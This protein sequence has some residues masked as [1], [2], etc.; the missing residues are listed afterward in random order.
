PPTVYVRGEI[1]RRESVV[2]IVGSRA[3]TPYGTRVAGDLARDLS[4]LGFAIVSGLAR[5]I[6]AAAHRGALEANGRTVAVL[7]GGLDHVTPRHHVQLAE[8]IAS[9]GGLISEWSAG[10]PAQPGM[11][12]RRNRLI[13]ALAAAV[14]VVEAGEQSGAL[15]TAAAARRLERPLFAVPGD[16]DRPQSRGCLMLLRGVAQH[17]L[18]LAFPE[19]TAADR[20][21][22]LREHY[23]ELGRVC[24]EYA[25]LGEL[26]RSPAGEVMAGIDGMEHIDRALSLGRGVILLTGHFGNFE[27]AAAALARSHPVDFI[28]KPLS[29]AE[30]ERWISAEREAAGVGQIPIGPSMRGA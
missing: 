19:L 5:G 12:V 30:M 10:P 16:I 25:R 24:V 17:N 29:N 21:A 2:A 15:S 8:E 11:F 3:A 22:I 28:V 23:R 9:S 6:D 4:L 14:V 18:D 26:S 27:L 13:A 20:A 7:A 1:P